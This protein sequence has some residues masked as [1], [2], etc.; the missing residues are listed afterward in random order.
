MGFVWGS[1][2]AGTASRG[3]C[4]FEFCIGQDLVTRTG[5]GRRY[6]STEMEMGENTGIGSFTHQ[7]NR[8]LSLKPLNMYLW[9]FSARIT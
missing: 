3:K 5:E 7:R 1:A 4:A 8:G 6:Q 2:A 9:N